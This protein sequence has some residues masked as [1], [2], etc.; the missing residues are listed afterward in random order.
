ME[1]HFLPLDDLFEHEA[2]EEC[3]CGPCEHPEQQGL[4]LHNEFTQE[5]IQEISK[6]IH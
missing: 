6:R 5:E 4:W 1:H 3:W 2:S